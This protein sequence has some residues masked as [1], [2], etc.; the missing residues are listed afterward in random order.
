MNQ[1]TLVYLLASPCFDHSNQI[2]RMGPKEKRIQIFWA[3]HFAKQNKDTILRRFALD[4]MDFDYCLMV[5]MGSNKLPVIFDKTL[6]ILSL[7]IF[8]RSIMRELC[9]SIF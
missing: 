1:G 5:S 9:W 4:L 2:C 3:M 6:K 8:F 7:H